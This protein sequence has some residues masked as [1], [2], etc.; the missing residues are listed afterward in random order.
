M[1]RWSSAHRVAQI[2]AQG[3]R[4]DAGL[5]PA[6]RVDVIEVITDAGVDVFGQRG[7]L[8]GA[9]LPEADNRPAGIWLNAGLDVT[10]QRHTAAHEWGHYVLNHGDR[11]GLDADPVT[12]DYAVVR[13]SLTETT[14][15]AFAAWLLM[16]RAAM[17]ATLRALGAARPLTP[18]NCYETSL[19]LGT[20]YKGTARHLSTAHLTERNS[21]TRL[22]RTTPA[23]IKRDLDDPS[24]PAPDPRTDIW[25]LTHF[26][27]VNEILT[28]AA[29]DRLI[30]DHTDIAAVDAL[31]EQDL[32]QFVAD[33]PTS[34]VLQAMAQVDRIPIPATELPISDALVRLR[35]D[36][37]VI[38]IADAGNIE[39]LTDVSFEEL[40]RRIADLGL[41]D[42]ND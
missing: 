17:L 30:L 2:A 29:G 25:R 22:M 37:P 33:T 14:A 41:T 23:R 13:R 6:D 39:D 11:C 40:A 24:A 1:S 8:F 16:P 20:S 3:A 38:G 19:I 32:A 31:I 5:E 12:V 27:A 42:V 7:C 21:S 36:Q 15:E 34:V 4:A 9:L 18:L 26:T 35:V 28:V 10:T